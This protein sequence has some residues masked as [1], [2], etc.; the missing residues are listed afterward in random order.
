MADENRLLSVASLKALAVIGG[1]SFILP[2]AAAYAFIMSNEGF[3]IG[4]LWAFGFWNLFFTVFLSLAGL[5]LLRPFAT[6]PSPVRLTVALLIGVAVGF[7]WT[8][9]VRFMLGPW[10]G[11]FSFPVLYCWVIGG[12]VTMPLTILLCGRPARALR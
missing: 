7:L 1:F 11:A 2:L 10:L 4:D 5:V 9:V 8:L 6:L 3:G 12:T